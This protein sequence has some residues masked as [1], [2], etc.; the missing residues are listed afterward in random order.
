MK[1]VRI[2][3]GI[4]ALLTCFLVYS[5]FS[6]NNEA[7]KQEAMMTVLVAAKNIPAQTQITDDMVAEK[8]IPSSLVLPDT[9]LTKSDVVGK[10]S[11]AS[12]VAQE[13]LL[14]GRFTK[15]SESGLAYTLK[16]GMR[17]ITLT[18]D[19]ETGIA[20]MVKV[21]N[22]VD[23]IVVSSDEKNKKNSKAVTFLQNIEVIALGGG[24][25]SKGSSGYEDVTLSVTPLDAEKLSLAVSTYGRV[26]GNNSLRLV[27]RPQEDKNTAA[28][29]SVT[30]QDIMG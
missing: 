7:A 16:N 2:I 28:V 3:A 30:I 8:Q 25:D 17:A 22:R 4:A 19:S 13:P 18:V 23:I 11:N 29:K 10:Y 20:D 6:G 9:V 5:F 14:K 12:I 15:P 24:T 26:K 21:G 27:L 1:K